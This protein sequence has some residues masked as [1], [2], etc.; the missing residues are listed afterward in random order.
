MTALRSVICTKQSQ[1]VLIWNFSQKLLNALRFAQ[2][3]ALRW[4]LLSQLAFP[5]DLELVLPSDHIT[6]HPSQGAPFTIASCTCTTSLIMM[7]HL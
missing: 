5:A 7:V 4:L 3:Q 2:K 6:G 1:A